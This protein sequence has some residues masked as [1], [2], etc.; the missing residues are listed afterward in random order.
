MGEPALCL[1][2]VVRTC[3]KAGLA[4]CLFHQGFF[5]LSECTCGYTQKGASR[6]T[7]NSAPACLRRETWRVLLLLLLLFITFV[8]VFK[9][10]YQI[11]KTVL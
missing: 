4:C 3:R 1:L 8:L 7:V 2:T 9:F 5:E 6:R 11:S 10:L